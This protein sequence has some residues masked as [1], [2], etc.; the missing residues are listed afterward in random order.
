LFVHVHAGKMFQVQ[1]P[2]RKPIIKV[3]HER[4]NDIRRHTVSEP[5]GVY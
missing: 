3:P 2:K 1:K 5:D 4:T